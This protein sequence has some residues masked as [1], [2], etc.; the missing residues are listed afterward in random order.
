MQK[1]EHDL[2]ITIEEN[3]ALAEVLIPAFE[4]NDIRRERD[5]YLTQTVSDLY[6]RVVYMV[7]SCGLEEG[8]HL[9]MD[10]SYRGMTASTSGWQES[11]RERQEMLKQDINPL[12]NQ[13]LEIEKFME[14]TK[15]LRQ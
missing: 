3:G 11:R 8:K 15:E 6:D 10:L 9:R 12:F 2:T 5:E 1:I 4:L 14:K 7:R 13:L